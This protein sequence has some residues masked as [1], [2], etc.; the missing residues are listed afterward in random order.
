MCLLLT[1]VCTIYQSHAQDLQKALLRDTVLKERTLLMPDPF[2]G[3]KALRALFPGKYYDLS[4]GK[5]VNR[6]I[7]WTCK[8]CATGSYND[9]NED[10]GQVF[11]YEEG[12]ATRLLAVLDF[13]DSAGGAYKLLAFQHSAYDADGMQTSRFTGGLLGLAKFTKTPRGW[14][15]RA[16]TPAI[17]AYGAFSSCPVP[18]LLK[19]G[20]DQYAVLLKHSNGPGGGPFDDSYFI[21]AG[22]GGAY[23]E[24]LAAWQVTRKQPEEGCSVWESTVAVAGDKKYFRDIIVTTKGIYRALEGD[25]IPGEIAAHVK[26]ISYCKFSFT[27]RFIYNASKGYVQQ[28]VADFAMTNVKQ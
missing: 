6:F 11:P 14:L 23:R 26:G 10:G 16:Y 7:S 12:V 20:A 19:I 13:K 25:N 1:S 9:V 5:Y 24:V 4:E 3:M 21:V 18:G 27:R 15:L 17:G 22:T 28:P 8:S 2:D